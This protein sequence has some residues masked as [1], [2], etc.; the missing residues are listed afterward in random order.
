MKN[1][2]SLGNLKSTAGLSMIELNINVMMWIGALKIEAFMIGLESELLI[3]TGLIMKKKMM[4]SMF[5][6][7]DS[8]V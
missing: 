2:G 8:G 5:G 6:R 1:I 7:K 3:R 4:N